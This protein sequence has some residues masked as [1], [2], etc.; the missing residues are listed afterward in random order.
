MEAICAVTD[1][2]ASV[3]KMTHARIA[4][5]PVEQIE[6]CER[7]VQPSLMQAGLPPSR[8]SSRGGAKKSITSL[9]SR[10]PCLVLRTS[11]ND[12][13]V[14]LVADPLFAAEAELHLCP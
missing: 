2:S 10:K 14:A 3:L 11:R 1:E 4:A 9:S 8:K 13:D 12:D 5:L 6:R 7:T